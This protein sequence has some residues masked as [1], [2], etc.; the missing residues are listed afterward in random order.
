MKCK[1]KSFRPLGENP[2]EIQG[3]SSRKLKGIVWKSNENLLHNQ[4]ESKN[5]MRMLW[6]TNENALEI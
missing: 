5:L 6:K 4:R 3:E 1:R 2:L